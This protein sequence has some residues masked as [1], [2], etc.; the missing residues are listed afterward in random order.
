MKTIPVMRDGRPATKEELM[1]AVKGRPLPPARSADLL[2]CPFCGTDNPKMKELAGEHW[3]Q[4]RG[5]RATSDGY[6]DAH[7][8]A[9]AWNRR[10][11]QTD[12]EP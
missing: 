1:A 5:C 11:D 4:C 12:R 3:V 6:L 10:N 7:Q 8:A 2:G 9:F